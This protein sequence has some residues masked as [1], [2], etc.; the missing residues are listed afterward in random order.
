MVLSDK[1][2]KELVKSQDLITPFDE[3]NLS[4]NSYDLTLDDSEELVLQPGESKLIV[5]KEFLNLPS[6][7]V[8][9]TISKSSFAR[10]GVSIGDIGGWIDAGYRGQ[11]TLLAVNYGDCVFRLRKTNQICQIVFLKSDSQ[12]EQTYNGHYQDSSGLRR[13][14]FD[15]NSE[16]Y[17]DVKVYTDIQ[18][19]N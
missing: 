18:S 2:I 3:G 7:I 9:K 6:D 15:E 4:S 10:C 12:A 14:W 1:S 11:L 16:D 17:R 8:A 13:A 5:T 19:L